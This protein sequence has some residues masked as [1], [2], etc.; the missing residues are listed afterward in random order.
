MSSHNNHKKEF[1]FSSWAVDNRTTVYLLTFIIVILG[2]VAYFSM[3]R[4]SFPEVVE[5]KVYISSV[6]PG[7]SAEDVEKLITKKLE[8]KFKNVSG[9]LEVTSNSFQDYCLIIVE[10]DDKTKLQEAKV[11]IK[12]K[13]DEAKGNQDWPNLDSGSKVEPSVFDLNISEEFPILNINIK[14]NYPKQTLKKYAE[15]IEDDMEDISEI[16]DA[17]IL[18]VDDN[19]VEIA[20]D[21][22]KMNAAQVS[23]DNVISA[24][25]N[26]N[27]TISG[28][29]LT[30]DGY[31]NNVRIKGQITN[32]NEVGDFIVKSGIKI[33]DIA[34][35][36]FKEKEKTTYAREMGQEVVMVN[37]KKRAGSNMIDA[38]DQAKEKL[39]TAQETYLP[40]DIEISAT[41]DQ[42]IQVEHQ[43]NELANHII[44]G[45]LLVM[46]VLSFSM[47]MKNSLFVGTAIPLSMLIAF[48]VLNAFGVTLNTMVLFAMVMG[49]G[50]LVD[51]GIVVVDN[52]YAN[53]EKGLSRSQASKFGIGEIAFPVITSTL[54]TLAAFAPMLLWP[55]IMGAFMKYFPITISVTLS[56]SLFV[57]MIINASMTGGSM[58][59]QDENL[60]TETNKK[61]T[62]LFTVVGV[63]GLIIGLASGNKSFFALT[64]L[65]VLAIAAIWLYK[66]YFFHKIQHF[67]TTF[68]PNLEVKYQDFLRKLLDGKPK[69]AFLYVV[70]LLIASFVIMGVSFATKW[71]KVL[72]FPDTMPQQMY[73]YMDFP[74]GTDIGKTNQT[75]KILEKSILN[76]ISKYKDKKTDKNFLIESMITEVGKGAINPQVDAGSQAD[77]PHK[78]KITINF[79]EY[80]D[81]RG[82]DTNDVLEE[83]RKAVPP[84]AGATITVEKQASGPPVGYPISIELKGNDYDLLIKESQRMISY[85]N[86]KNI[87]GIERLQTDVNKDS[88]EMI[89]DVDREVAGNLGVSTAYTGIT[90]RRAMFGQDISTFKDIEDDYQISVRLQEDQR[91]NQSELFNQPITF[92]NEKGQLLQIPISTF[93]KSTEEKTFSKIKRKDNTRTIMVYSNITQD[94][95]ANEIIGKLKTDMKNYQLPDGVSFKFA[96]E[97]EEQGKNQ[98][99]LLLALFLAMSMVTGIIV[100]QFNSMSKTV[101]IMTTI[102][103]SFSGV[104]LGLTVF[105]MDFV[106]LM[107]MMGIISLAGVV[108]KNGIVLMDFFVLRLDDKIA[109]KGVETH[110]DLTIDEVKEVIIESGKARLRPVLLT[111]TTAVLGLIPLAIG[112]NFD[113]WSFLTTLNPHLSLGGDNVAFWGPLA[114]TIIFGLT[115]ATFLTLL[116]VPVMFYLVSKLKIRRRTRKLEKLQLKQELGNI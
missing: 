14:G 32:P 98:S 2:I 92:R 61:L 13:V 73:V 34:T 62:I 46:G 39:K 1:F 87:S 24:V 58:T 33:S 113:I 20:L 57:A 95:N 53:M 31:R 83:I 59:L 88:P 77:T 67:Q 101:I 43:V 52:V 28:G 79:V 12:D 80:A 112:L 68:F 40:K 10:F 86:S 104:F 15:Q 100:F 25:K 76:T 45:I 27:I 35:V 107:T 108:V 26:E 38:I 4:E 7:N 114:W 55:G 78:S 71:T 66:N 109:E 106:I 9:V 116:I 90:L 30:T 82:V 111:A 97:Q 94:A 22:Y 75:T 18:G 37:L 93:A 41:S 81:R 44:I 64:T 16:K 69:K 11:R 65:S 51:D 99:F 50:M 42:S 105:K 17:V 60:T 23:F 115:F 56:A 74:Q 91:K 49:L 36:A 5:N 3:P 63:A 72:F 110:D 103:L 6:Y 84:I 21:L 8:D 70:G 89:I 48:A 19:E 102:L 85:I 47:G 54:T 96:G 29:N